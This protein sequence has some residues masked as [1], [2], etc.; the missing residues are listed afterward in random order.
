MPNPHQYIV[1]GFRPEFKVSKHISLPVMVGI[2]AVRNAY[3]DGRSLSAFFKAMGRE[4]DPCFQIAPYF[5]VSIV[6][7]ACAPACDSDVHFYTTDWEELPSSSFLTPPVMKDFLSLPDTVM[8]YEVRDAGEKAD[9]LL[10]K[11]DL[12]A[13]DNTLTFTFTTTDYMD[14]EAAEK[15]K[16]YLRRPVVYVWKEGSYELQATSNE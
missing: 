8:D 12:S 13:K 5:S 1:V 2:N 7:T 15:L 4:Y 10:V 3:Y 16:P 11:A 14:K 6:S 9:M